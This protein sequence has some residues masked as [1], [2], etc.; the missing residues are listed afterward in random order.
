MKEPMLFNT[1]S[2]EPLLGDDF[3]FGVGTAAYQIEGGAQDDGRTDSVWDTFCRRQGTIADQS[4]GDVACDHYH[5]WQEDVALLAELGVDVYRFSVSWSRVLPDDTGAVNRTGLD[6]YMRLINELRSRGIRPMVTLHHWD[7]PQYLQDTGGWQNRKTSYRFAEYAAL[8]ARE[9]DQS[10]DFYTTINEPWCIAVLGHSTGVHAPG[11]QDESAANSA[12]H[13]LLLGHGL[14]IR[15]LREHAPH[16]EL[17]IV[18]NGGPSHPASDSAEDIVAAKTAETDQIHRFAGPILA[19]KYPQELADSISIYVHAGDLEII[20]EPCD[21][22]GWNYYTRS[23]VKSGE[24]GK[25]EAVEDQKLPVTAMGW[26]VFPEGLR[27]VIEILNR[28]YVLPPL[29]ISENGA[30]YDDTVDGDSVHDA[31]RT[32]YIQ[33]HL[34]VVADM[35]SAGFDIR[36]YICWTL[37]DNFEWAEGYTKR[38]GL[39]RVNYDTQERTVKDSGRAFA[40]LMRKRRCQRAATA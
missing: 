6:F 29:Y 38:F 35:I 4:S 25:P 31:D 20:A 13:H 15:A 7:L 32:Q 9:F 40:D 3:I 14:A 24:I 28:D 22:L 37:L 1:E 36:G 5:R 2:L 26:E 34:E 33:Q 16:A 39:V 21:Y 12:T 17:G 27:E 30:A 11:I 19:G 23:V 8:V 18:L 10:V